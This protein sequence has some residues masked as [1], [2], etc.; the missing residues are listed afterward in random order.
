[1]STKIDLGT[2]L[3]ETLPTYA[4]PP[5][6][7]EWAREHAPADDVN[8][9]APEANKA[10]LRA[11]KVVRL[12]LY[13]AGLLVASVLGW[14]ASNSYRL[15]QQSVATQ[16]ALIVELV[17]THVRSLMGEHL[18]DVRSADQHTVKPWFVGKTDFAPRVLDLTAKGFPLLGG[19]IE[20][21]HGH[22]AAAVVYGRRRHI[23]NVFM[24]PAAASENAQGSR[25]Y[26]GYAM[27]HWVAD[28]LS[29]WAVSDAAPAELEAFR[30]AYES[31][32]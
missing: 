12:L 14:T 8:A 25:Q 24:W 2:A 7:H 28:G 17:D 11:P 26:H 18:M 27:L 32:R 16:D 4:A 5:S 1:V 20:Y 15:H 21:I 3:R 6:L 13:A 23:V 9:L 30:Q 31:T 19:R 29:Y 22:T 10:L